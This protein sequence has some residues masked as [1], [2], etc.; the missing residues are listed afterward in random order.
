MALMAAHVDM[1]VLGIGATG[2]AAI[3]DAK[4]QGATG[5][6]SE[7]LDTLPIT[8]EAASY[9][10]AGGDCRGLVIKL[11]RDGDE[12]LALRENRRRA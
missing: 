3:R 11:D 1:L 9:V 4:R 6:E 12:Y 8:G 5:S 2:P 10:R 7:G